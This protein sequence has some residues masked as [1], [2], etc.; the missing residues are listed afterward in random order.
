MVG[1]RWLKLMFFKKLNYH[2][3]K[4]AKTMRVFMEMEHIKIWGVIF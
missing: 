4:I 3:I 1:D 2:I